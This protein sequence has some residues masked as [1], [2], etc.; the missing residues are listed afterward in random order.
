MGQAF[1]F[2][3]KRQQQLAL[4]EGGEE[5][6]VEPE[7]IKQA[8]SSREGKS[9]AGRGATDK[10][11][12]LSDRQSVTEAG[13]TEEDGEEQGEKEEKLVAAQKNCCLYS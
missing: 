2:A 7:A 9:R 12:C 3:G 1:S 8:F 11:C 4:P 5:F 10:S 13:G 6:Q